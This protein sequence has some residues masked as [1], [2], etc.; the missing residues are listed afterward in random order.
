[1]KTNITSNR[2][3]SELTSEQ[4]YLSMKEMMYGG[5]VWLRMSEAHQRALKTKRT[6][7]PVS[8]KVSVCT[9]CHA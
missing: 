5:C 2:K 1:M 6:Q 9:S 8:A 7:L 3:S 4:G